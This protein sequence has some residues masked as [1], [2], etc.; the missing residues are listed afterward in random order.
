MFWPSKVSWLANVLIPI[1]Y[2][3]FPWEPKF[4]ILLLL[5]LIV[6]TFPLSMSS[7]MTA[8]LHRA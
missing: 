4:I 3:K 1:K 6:D 5:L 8:V 7:K 2:Y